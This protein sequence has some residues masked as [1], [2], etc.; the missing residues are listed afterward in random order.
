MCARP[1][2]ALSR[3]AAR[4]YAYSSA[5][6]DRGWEFLGK[7]SAPS[8]PIPV[9]LPHCPAKL[10]WQNWNPELWEDIWLY[11]K[12]FTRPPEPG[13]RTFLNFDGAAVTTEITVNG[14]VLP[15]HQGGYLPFAREITSLLRDSNT[16]E[17]RVD[18]RFQ[19]VPPEGSPKGRGSIDYFVPGGMIRGAT[20]RTVPAAYI[21][22]VF[23]KPVD[24][25]LPSRRVELLCT[26]DSATTNNRPATIIAALADKDRVVARAGT[27]ISRWHTGPNEV[28]FTLGKLNAVKLWDTDNPNLYHLEVA[29]EIDGRPVHK[30]R[31][32]IGFRE[33]KFTSDGFFL[34]GK[35]VKF[36]G[37]NRHE[38]YPYTGFAMPSRVMRRDAEI[39]R[40]EF[41]CDI[42]R[43]SHYPQH[44]SFL[45]AC[46][47]LGLMVWEETPGWQYIGD[48]EFQ[49]QVVENVHDMILRDRNHPSIVIWGVR[50]NE[51]H[52][53]PSL[54]DR[55][56]AAAKQLDDSRPTSGSMTG[57]GDWKTKWH[58]DV[59]AFDD[60]HQA[61]DGTVQVLP[62]LPDIPYMLAETVGQ[63]SYTVE[64]FHNMY[65]R[66]AE[67]AMQY[68]QAIYHAQAHDRAR[69]Y[70]RMC[71]VI[72]WCAFEYGSPQNSYKGVKNPGVADVFRIPKLGASFYQTQ[73]SP[74]KRPA[75]E[76]NFY[77]DFGAMTPKGPGKAIAIFHNCDRLEVFIDDKLQATLEPDRV[78][79]PNLLHPPSFIDIE[80]DG[81]LHPEL[82]IE[83]FVATEK[84]LARR[85][86]SDP[87][88]DQFIAQADD[89][90]ICG[91]GI[92][93]TRIV[94]RVTDEY[95]NPRLSGS[96]EV[97]I[98]VTGPGE[99]MGDRIVSLTETGGA[100]AV[101]VRS[102]PCADGQILLQLTHSTKGTRTLAVNTRKDGGIPSATTS[103]GSRTILGK[104]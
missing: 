5:P 22:D 102:L 87:S 63:R 80:T 21:A 45:D 95:G 33:A 1:L 90:E 88:K 72:A 57:F 39:I 79:F 55:T 56:Y 78:G 46:D 23:A 101:W 29:L 93:A 6:F 14:T 85:F 10:S 30:Y 99:L 25:L 50:V 44:E 89:P 68:H 7:A 17:V 66:A 59:F 3:A 42:V 32:R 103:C 92:D 70:D 4:G 40:H 27:T 65:R 67:P 12:T 98:D 2:A 94:F 83:G 104:L 75:I 76:P 84:V 52:N 16:V 47:E 19:D 60:Y 18:A 8:T 96:G 9:T 49:D 77:W 54:Y 34:N 62:P 41:N 37:L 91:D 43:C 58:E 71:G 31:T 20:L 86:S 53:D 73:V 36:F 97:H 26:I 11:R 64:G 35:R 69:A 61:P 24:V 15:P 13:S 28:S 51:S 100:A 48:Q 82:R 74:L 38:L 81:T